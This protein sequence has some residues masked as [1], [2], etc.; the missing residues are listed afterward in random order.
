MRIIEGFE[1]FDLGDFYRKFL[2]SDFFCL[3]DF[4]VVLLINEDRMLFFIIN[5][6]VVCEQYVLMFIGCFVD[7][8]LMIYFM[9]ESINNDEECSK[10]F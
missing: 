6:I 4:S 10:F 2:N 8:Y 3:C 7:F 5:L 1:V 9:V